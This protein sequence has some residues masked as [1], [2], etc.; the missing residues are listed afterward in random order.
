MIVPR[1]LKAVRAASARHSDRRRQ[2]ERRRFGADGADEARARHD[3]TKAL[4]GYEAYLKRRPDDI[5]IRLRM[6]RVHLAAGHFE[7]AEAAMLEVLRRRPA[8]ADLHAELAVVREAAGRRPAYL[9]SLAD[10]EAQEAP[11][12]LGAKTYDAFRQ[13]LE[14]PSAPSGSG[15]DSEATILIDARDFDPAAIGVTLRALTSLHGSWRAVVLTPPD[16]SRE[17]KGDV[18]EPDGRVT[19]CAANDIPSA[20]P[21]SGPVLLLLQGAVLAPGALAW[22]QYALHRSAAQAVYCDHDHFSVDESGRRHYCSP[23][24]QGEAHREDILTTPFVPPA[25]LFAGEGATITAW[26]NGGENER[27]RRRGRLLAAFDQGGVVHVPLLLVSVQDVTDPA[28]ASPVGAGDVGRIGQPNPLAMTVCDA[29]D[30]ILVVVPTRDEAAVLETMVDSLVRFADQP[31]R[32][33]FLVVDNGSL[34]TATATLLG[35]WRETGRADVIRVDE[36]FNWSRLNNLAVVG[37]DE[38]ILLFINNDMEMLTQG[39]DARLCQILSRASVGAVGARMI[40][41]DGD[42]QHAGMALNALDGAPLH[43]ALGEKRSSA[44]PLDRWVRSRPA[45]AVTGAYIGVR[46]NVFLTVGGFDEAHFPLSCNDVDFCMRI[47]AEGLTVVYDGETELVHFESRTRGHADTPEK[48]RQ[49]QHEL[50]RLKAIWGGDLLRDPARNPHW[51]SHNTRL[52]QWLG[53]PTRDQ[54]IDHI[55]RAGTTWSVRKAVLKGA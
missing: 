50:D 55:D 44:G 30:R 45:S 46:R 12:R 4:A 31:A 27:D 2:A 28:M 3:F 6:A 13:S 52:F 22:L 15:A 51:I 39:W 47:R 23:A 29:M 34:E 37:R 5:G 26:L 38:D 19:W 41:P 33:S 24:L 17:M 9:R 36:P 10:I 8:K 48:A 14:L 53:C 11:W 18:R 42:V 35:R 54:V 16:F 20:P 43:E 40:Y 25:I 32:L 21:L 7:A 1:W 49:A